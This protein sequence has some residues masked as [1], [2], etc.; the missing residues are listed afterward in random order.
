MRA[1]YKARRDT[2]LAALD[3]YAPPGMT[4]TR[5]TGGY[6]LWCRL[7]RGV[8]GRA[9]AAEAARRASRGWRATSF[10]RRAERDAVRLNFTGAPEAMIPEG[11]RRVC[12][13]L[14]RL[15]RD[16]GATVSPALTGARPVV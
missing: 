16:A 13:T 6:Y 8:P 3:T 9:L 12:T 2:M 11:V 14:R 15:S 10:P 7:P 5:P 4:W 1:V